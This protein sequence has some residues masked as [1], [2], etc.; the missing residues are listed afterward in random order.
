MDDPLLMGGRETLGRLNGD[1][2]RGVQIEWRGLE[3]EIELYERKGTHL[4]LS[5][6][7]VDELLVLPAKRE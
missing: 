2:H 3:L 5:G 4:G 1:I 7:F 6:W